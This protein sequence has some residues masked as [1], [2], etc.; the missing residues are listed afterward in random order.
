[1]GVRLENILWLGIKELRGLLADP[2]LL[3]LIGFAFTVAVYAVGTGAKT[4]VVHGAVGIV[5][6][7]R[8]E[9]SRR[10][11]GAVL[12]PYFNPRG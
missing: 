5:D 10:I 3:L 4:E 8:S 6:E 2:V 1:M 7:D 9:L 11:A 12:E